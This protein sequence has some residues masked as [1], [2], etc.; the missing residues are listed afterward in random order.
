[1]KKFDILYNCICLDDSSNELWF[2][3]N[4][5]FTKK[6]LIVDI[7][8][9]YNKPNNPINIYKE[10]TTFENPV[11]KYN[12]FVDIIAINNLPSLLPIDSSIY[13]SNILAI[14]LLEYDKSNTWIN[15]MKKYY[16]M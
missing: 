5:E 2:D 6:I 13:F 4:T 12:D 8:C 10:A 14:L 16:E 1:M 15:N 3:K 11:Y 9:D 7:S